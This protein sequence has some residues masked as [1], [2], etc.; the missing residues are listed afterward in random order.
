MPIATIISVRGTE[1]ATILHMPCAST[2][3]IGTDRRIVADLI[4]C[5]KNEICD[6]CWMSDFSSSPLA[7][8]EQTQAPRS[9]SGIALLIW[10]WLICAGALA[11]LIA[12]LNLADIVRFGPV[13]V[14]VSYAAWVLFW[15]PTVAVAS[16]ELV[17]RNLIRTSTI[18]WTAVRRIETRWTLTI[19]TTTGKIVAWAAPAP[20]RRAGARS[21]EPPQSNYYTGLL[22]RGRMPATESGIAALS[23]R[24][25]WQHLTDSGVLH[26]VATTDPPVVTTWLVRECAI[27]CA[28]AVVAV[29]TIVLVRS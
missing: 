29:A 17:V 4:C 23:V 1:F 26:G 20:S 14:F 28:L 19:Y 16:T 12:G 5:N 9:R 21:S 25:Y 6:D 13:I 27:L 8:G 18:P 2:R 15:A 24:D 3:A 11:S 10:V 22:R 7:T